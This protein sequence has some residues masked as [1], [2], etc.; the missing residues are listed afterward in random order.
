M[1]FAVVYFLLRLVLRLA[2]EGEDRDREAEI[3][4][5]R[6]QLKVLSRKAGSPR[7]R[8]LDRMLL[9]AFS[10][11][12][13]RERWGAFSVTPGTLLRW[14]R[15]LVRRK[16]TY[17]KNGGGRPRIDQKIQDLILTMAKE[18]P[19]WGY[20]RIKG[21]C[22]KLGIR[23]AANTIKAILSR[24]GLG[25]APRRGPSWSDFLRAQAQ[26]ILACDFFTVETVFLRTLYVLFFIEVG[27]RRLHITPATRN[28]DGSFVTQQ[29]RNLFMADELQDVR[30]LIRDRDSKYI[31]SF[32]E[33]FSSGG[34]RVIKTP[35]RSPKANAFAER[36]VRTIRRDLLDWTLVLG[37]RHLDRILR[38]YAE[39]YNAE[40]P[41]RG[42]ELAVPHGPT[43]LQT[44]S[45]TKIERRMY[46][47]DSSTST[48]RSP[49]E[50]IR[51]FCTLHPRV[52][53]IDVLG[54]L[55]HEY[56]PAAA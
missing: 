5:L 39:H 53:R 45:S 36:V 20:M 38:R 54:G 42:L 55:I 31:R 29:A 1:F 35:V 24:A 56:E 3:L 41:H 30:F 26:G 46:S 23:I 50:W 4:V 44:D 10:R 16:R 9:A 22:Q 43:L 21:E 7:L 40:R 37:R 48:T 11:L 13:P 2:P 8:R 49:H 51:G 52:R 34:T 28:P 14:H 33:V 12:L 17:N 15:D 47:V 25:P 18:N 6:H 19:R 32:D 27:T